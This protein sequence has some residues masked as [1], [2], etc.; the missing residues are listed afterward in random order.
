MYTSTNTALKVPLIDIRDYNYISGKKKKS[1]SSF[2]SSP[3][4]IIHLCFPSRHFSTFVFVFGHFFSFQY[5]WRSVLTVFGILS[6]LK[7]NKKWKKNR[8]SEIFLALVSF[9][10]CCF[11][12]L[13]AIWFC[14]LYSDRFFSL[15]CLSHQYTVTLVNTHNGTRVFSAWNVR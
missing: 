2:T 12:S 8:K 1:R 9:I 14:V 5:R 6:V 7:Q 4:I 13:Q 15:C 10:M 3:I 11:R